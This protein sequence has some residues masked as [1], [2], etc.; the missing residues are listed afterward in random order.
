MSEQN[1]YSTP[2]QPIPSPDHGQVPPQNAFGAPG[3]VPPQEAFAAPGQVPPP[4]YGYPGQ[5]AQ[6]GQPWPGAAYGYPG[7][8]PKKSR[9]GLW[10]TLGCVVG[11]IVIAGGVLTYYVADVASKT[12][13]HKVVLPQTFEQ[14]TMDTD[15]SV[16]K[17]LQ[18]GMEQSF[19]SGAHPWKATPVSAVY[20]NDDSGR[21]AV[22]FGAYGDVVLPS[23]QLNAF[24]DSFESSA[25]SQGSTFEGRAS[26][27]AG[28][29]GGSMSCER[30]HASSGEVD[31][32]CAWA[33]GSSL[34]AVME[35]NKNGGDGD[36]SKAASDALDM[37]AAAE[38]PK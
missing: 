29:L 2:Q 30:M 13:T 4:G 33:D 12:G 19:S 38:L 35:T 8:P 14:M 9:K 22:V 10:I 18:D 27:P 6:P 3:E 24:W 37:R 16:A 21:I 36:L 17:Q 7:P 28:P 5:P 26:F 11:A 15:N 34:V 20:L 1:P 23:T 32:I 31:T 25:K